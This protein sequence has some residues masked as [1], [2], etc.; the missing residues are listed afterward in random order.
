M[1]TLNFPN[2][3]KTKRLFDVV[4][5]LVDDLGIELLTH[6]LFV[7]GVHL[8]HGFSIDLLGVFVVSA[9]DAEHG[10]PWQ[11]ASSKAALLTRHENQRARRHAITRY[12]RFDFGLLHHSGHL[13][14]C[15]QIAALSVYQNQP[16]NAAFGEGFFELQKVL[17]YRGPCGKQ[18]VVDPFKGHGVAQRG[19]PQQEQEDP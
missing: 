13:H 4:K 16:L 5:R 2:A 8:R 12:D 6:L 3:Q 17:I 18:V 9:V 11:M 10:H 7:Q 1:G 15:P 14:A 19:K